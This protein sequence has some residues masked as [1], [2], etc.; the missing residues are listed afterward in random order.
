MA[1]CDVISI[2][3]AAG[4]FVHSEIAF[5]FCILYPTVGELV[6]IIKIHIKTFISNT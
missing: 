4:K 1:G 5:M 3:N 6:T 2:V